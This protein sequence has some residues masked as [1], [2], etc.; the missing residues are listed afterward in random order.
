[1]QGFK[2]SHILFTPCATNINPIRV[3]YK[4]VSAGGEEYGH[5]QSII[6]FKH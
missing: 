2:I 3:N 6:G 4:S 5:G 1:M